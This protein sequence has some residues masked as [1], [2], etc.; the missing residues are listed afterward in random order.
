MASE[1]VDGDGVYNVMM[2]MGGQ[3]GR[4]LVYWQCHDAAMDGCCRM[5]AMHRIV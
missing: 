2:G 4:L 3:V 5:A 1:L